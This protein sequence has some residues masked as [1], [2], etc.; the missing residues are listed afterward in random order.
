MYIY[1][2]LKSIRRG[3]VFN[4]FPPSPHTLLGR[5]REGPTVTVFRLFWRFRV[6]KR[7]FGERTTIRPG[8]TTTDGCCLICKPVN[9]RVSKVPTLFSIRGESLSLS[10]SLS[11]ISLA[12]QLFS[13]QRRLCNCVLSITPNPFC[14]CILLFVDLNNI[15]F[16]WAILYLLILFIS[17]CTVQYYG[18]S[19]NRS[20]L[21]KWN[22]ELMRAFIVFWNINCEMQFSISFQFLLFFNFF[23]LL[24]IPKF[25]KFWYNIVRTLYFQ[26]K[27][28]NTKL[29]KEI[30]FHV[31]CRSGTVE[32][33]CM[34]ISWL[35]TH[36]S[37]L[38]CL[39]KSIMDFLICNFSWKW[40]C[41]NKSSQMKDFFSRRRVNVSERVD[42]IIIRRPYIH[43][44]LF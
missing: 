8:Q 25:E 21:V 39:C 1:T 24:E 38:K 4:V 37:F 2:V 43:V 42:W 34:I 9:Q 10:L 11:P 19:I 22:L 28:I 35:K 26:L 31:F 29:R 36:K 41:S 14:N 44:F 16:M 12:Q 17:Y 23:Q 13:L 30:H 32:I 20:I 6:L 18:S 40:P 27:K 33:Q 15:L 7:L 3:S 5:S